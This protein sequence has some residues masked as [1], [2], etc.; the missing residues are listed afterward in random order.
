MNRER[1]TPKSFNLLLYVLITVVIVVIVA[2]SLY[3]VL[4]IN[5]LS[6]EVAKNKYLAM[7]NNLKIETLA[8]LDHNFYGTKSEKERINAYLPT[9]KDV[10]V[11]LSDLERMARSNNLV[12]SSYQVINDR[13][14]I[15]SKDKA[16]DVQ[17]QKKD[18]YYFLSFM[19]KLDGSYNS[20]TKMIQ[21]MESYERLIEVSAIKYTKK[22]EAGTDYIEAEINLNAY[23]KP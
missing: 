4:D 21:E 17:I 19:I 16:Q 13:K 7:N 18:N 6:K 20:I 12:F 22:F 2:F 3:F 1:L 8:E 9:S 15:L 11:L 14:A 10:S 5:R 23:L